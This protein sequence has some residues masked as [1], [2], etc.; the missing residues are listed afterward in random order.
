MPETVHYYTSFDLFEKILKDG[1]IKPDLEIPPSRSSLF[2]TNERWEAMTLLATGLTMDELLA[3]GVRLVRITF[4]REVAPHD[5]PIFSQVAQIDAKTVEGFE[6]QARKRGADPAEWRF[7]FEEVPTDKRIDLR[8][9]GGSE[10][11]ELKT[12]S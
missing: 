1:A 9:W 8:Q 7:S 3:S 2:S 12:P 5:W 6:K 10:W 4:P 11:V